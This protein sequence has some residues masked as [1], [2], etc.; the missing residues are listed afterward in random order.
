MKGLLYYLI[1][2]LLFS[3][4]ARS[5][6]VIDPPGQYY[7]AKSEYSDIEMYY[8]YDVL[9]STKN[10]RYAKKQIKKGLNV[11]AVKIV[12]TTTQNITIGQTAKFYSGE[13]EVNLLD[14]GF[15][16]KALKQTTPS[17]LLYLLLTPTRFVA[18]RNGTVT[19]NIPIGVLLGPGLAG[20]N[21]AFAASANKK[22]K[23]EL[24][25][26][27]LNNK[28]IAPGQTVYGLI[29]FRNEEFLPLKL[30]IIK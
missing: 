22:F 25:L 17:Y 6:Y 3:S 8:K 20:G 11:V 7:S 12:N 13:N 29:S 16:H 24:F 10:K 9:A 4:C 5:F 27:D 18:T 15:T 23:E 1:T 14:M 19:T 26:Y 21:I 30:K 2:I 28:Q